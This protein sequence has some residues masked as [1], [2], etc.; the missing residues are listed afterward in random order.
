MIKTFKYTLP[1]LLVF[2]VAISSCRKDHKI[3]DNPSLKLEFST[4][5]IIFDTV[6]TTVGSITRYLKVYNRHDNALNISTIRLLGGTSSN[7][8]INVDGTPTVQENDVTIAGNDSLFLF[9]RVTIDPGNQN[10]PFVVSDEVLFITNG[11][12]QSVVLAAWGQD[13]HYIIADKTIGN[14][15]Y[16]IVAAEDS[17]VIWP[18]DKPYLV[19]GYAV[20]DSTGSLTIEEGAQIH[21]HNQ[22]GLWVY[23]GGSLKVWGSKENPV[24]F[25]QDRLEPY[26]R[27]LP[28]QWDRIWLNEGSINN[29]IN[30]AVIRNG[31]I[32]LQA[33]TLQEPMGNQLILTNTIIENMSGIGIL[34]RYYAITGVNN[35]IANCGQLGVLLQ[36]GLYDFRQCTFANYFKDGIRQDPNFAMTNYYLDPYDVLYIYPLDAYFG[37]NIIYGNKSEEML[38]DSD[39]QGDFNYTFDHCLLKTEMNIGDEEHFPGSIKNQDPFF[40]DVDNNKLALDTLSPGID[41]GSVDVINT[42]PLPAIID[43]DILGVSRISSPDIGAYEYIP[44]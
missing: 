10:L 19:Y 8:R 32:G 44:E 2:T 15:K 16:K 17:T 20:V 38:L 23:K 36:G 12:E 39:E 37:N 6:F 28:G 3:D 42:S 29:E 40:V 1:F 5:S 25:Q 18:A 11:N 22:S 21:F 9:V 30:Y 35:V 13:A 34:G 27:D 7:F 14:L 33:E 24:V 26:F 4:D 31:F 41:M 43:K